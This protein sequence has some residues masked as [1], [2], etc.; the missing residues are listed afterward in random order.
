M[1]LSRI[2]SPFLVIS[3]EFVKATGN[4]ILLLQEFCILTAVNQC[5]FANIAG[6]C[7]DHCFRE[8]QARLIRTGRILKDITV[9]MADMR[10]KRNSVAALLICPNPALNYCRKLLMSFAV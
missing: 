4:D 8:I 3:D 6:I 10:S 5:L 1:I 2:H 7:N 9:F